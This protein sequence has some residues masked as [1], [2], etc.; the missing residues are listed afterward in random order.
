[1]NG[2]PLV[3]ASVAGLTLAHQAS[4]GSRS[5]RNPKMPTER[6]PPHRITGSTTGLFTGPAT[7]YRVIDRFELD[8]LADAYADDPN[9]RIAGGLYSVPGEREG[10]AAF[11]SDPMNVVQFGLRHATP[12]GARRPGRKA[13]PAR[14]LAPLT[15][16]E[17]EAE[18]LPFSRLSM[19]ARWSQSH[20][21]PD[22]L[23]PLCSA[24]LGCN[25]RPRIADITA[26]WRVGEDGTL[27]PMDV[28]ATLR[29][30]ATGLT[31]P[32]AQALQ[33]ID[34]AAKK[35][36]DLRV[37]LEPDRSAARWAPAPRITK[38][39]VATAQDL[40]RGIAAARR[41]L[42]ASP[43][44]NLDPAWIEPHVIESLPSPLPGKWRVIWKASGPSKTSRTS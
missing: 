19:D 28:L 27:T 10:G 17:V 42:Q 6:D 35:L 12:R 20:L 15:L 3:L 26:A 44:A 38:A 4:K 21:A 9:A 22:D 23:E 30:H 16:I 32:V 5:M 11:G 13:D 8:L 37:A 14:L 7:L 24:G 36:Y 1:M 29:Q 25:I 39:H 40:F 43:Y 31:H 2:L 18:G 33:A 41:T 34:D